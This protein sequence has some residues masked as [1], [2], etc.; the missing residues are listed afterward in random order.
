MPSMKELLI[1]RRLKHTAMTD[2]QDN[3]PVPP[4]EYN[5][6]DKNMAVMVHLLPLLGFLFPGM[7]ILVPLLIWLFKRD[8]SSYIEHHAREAL[9]FQIT[10]AL[11]VAIWIALKLM[12]VG[13]LLLPL[14]PIIIIIVLILMIRA[15]LKAS[16]GEYYLYP[17]SL[18]LVK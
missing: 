12:L 16:D 8:K 7:S 14:V 3:R 1:W 9:N 10:I 2:F 4:P 11:V 5:R 15:A 18:R 6:D 13:L 17:F